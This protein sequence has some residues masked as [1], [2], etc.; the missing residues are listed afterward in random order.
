MILSKALL[1]EEGKIMS[2]CPCCSHQLL[3]HIH[4]HEVYWFCRNCWQEMPMLSSE[5]NLSQR[6]WKTFIRKRELAVQYLDV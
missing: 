4:R 2:T 1:I 3:R 5:D 6:D